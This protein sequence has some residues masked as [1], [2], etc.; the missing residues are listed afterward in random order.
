MEVEQ[1]KSREGD[2]VATVMSLA[3]SAGAGAY[4]VTQGPLE[5][6]IVAERDSLF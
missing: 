3:R 4:C 2:A 1:R 5:S 6:T